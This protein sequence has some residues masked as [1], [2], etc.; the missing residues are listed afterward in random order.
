M[1]TN[2]VLVIDDE[3]DLLESLQIVLQMH[4]FKPFLA[5]NVHK[6]LD[7]LAQHPIDIILC[8]VSLPDMSG[9]EALAKIKSNTTWANIPF[10][11]ITAM[12]DKEDIRLGLEAGADKYIT[13][14]FSSKE[15]ILLI[16]S[17]IT[18]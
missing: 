16:K 10:V 5:E 17:F 6:G 3:R 9:L 7:F 18:P 15:L 1:Q 8:D 14:P 13:K 12:A 11:F 4:G 2:N